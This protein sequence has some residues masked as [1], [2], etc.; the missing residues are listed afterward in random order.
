[1]SRRTTRGHAVTV[2]ALAMRPVVPQLGAVGR[3]CGTHV[4][5]YISP[6]VLVGLQDTIF[7]RCCFS[8]GLHAEA[9]C[10]QALNTQH[11]ILNVREEYVPTFTMNRNKHNQ[12][13]VTM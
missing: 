10:K 12:L 2:P 6:K 9:G 3:L 8:G 5:R 13:T 11:S 1:V 4:D 7:T